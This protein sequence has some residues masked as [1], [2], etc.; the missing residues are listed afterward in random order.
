MSMALLIFRMTVSVKSLP[1]HNICGFVFFTYFIYIL[2]LFLRN[3]ADIL[4]EGAPWVLNT[5]SKSIF[6]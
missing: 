6:G 4:Y 3:D 2:Y 1:P 5:H